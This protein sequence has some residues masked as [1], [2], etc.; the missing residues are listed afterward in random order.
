[1]VSG[2]D[3]YWRNTAQLKRFSVREFVVR[4]RWRS[5]RFLCEKSFGGQIPEIKEFSIATEVFE[6]RD[7]GEACSFV[8][9]STGSEKTPA[10][11][12]IAGL[13]PSAA[14]RHPARQLP[15]MFSGFHHTMPLAMDTLAHRR[16]WCPAPARSWRAS[17]NPIFHARLRSGPLDYRSGRR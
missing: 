8:G 2:I 14:N 1:M 4:P 7:F 16:N 5:L 6:D 12:C 11:L 3:R 10:I 17:N 13:D 9:K 15:A